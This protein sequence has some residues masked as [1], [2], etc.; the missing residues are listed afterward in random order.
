MLAL[1]TLSFA[2]VVN[3]RTIYINETGTPNSDRVG[4]GARITGPARGIGAV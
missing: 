1:V 3:D 4:T 2:I